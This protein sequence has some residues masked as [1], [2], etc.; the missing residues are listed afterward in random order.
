MSLL[1]GS[2]TEYSRTSFS[3][4]TEKIRLEILKSMNITQHHPYKCL[5]ILPSNLT[6]H[7]SEGLL[8]VHFALSSFRQNRAFSVVGP[9][10]W[11][12]IPL[13]LRLFPRTTLSLELDR[14]IG[15][16]HHRGRLWD[17]RGRLWDNRN[18][19]QMM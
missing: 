10:T 14:Y 17:N 6:L 5:L 19:R 1:G 12:G 11:N 13:E 18:H 2:T 15:N 4:I 3:H 8:R 7:S 16:T 9:L